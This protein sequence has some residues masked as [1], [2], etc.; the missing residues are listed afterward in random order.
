MLLVFSGLWFSGMTPARAGCPVQMTD[1]VRLI[2]VH[3]PLASA[4]AAVAGMGI[5]PSEAKAL[6]GDARSIRLTGSRANALNALGDRY[7][8]DW[9]CLQDGLHVQPSGETAYCMFVEHPGGLSWQQFAAALRGLGAFGASFRIQAMHKTRIA[10]IS[11]PPTLV[12]LG[13]RLYHSLP[14][15]GGLRIANGTAITSI[16]PGRADEQCS[17]LT[18]GQAEQ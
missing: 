15:S 4:T 13:R 16:P 8:F 17:G 18:E 5:K 9:W 14:Q 11:G 1:Q 6:S 10:M 2:V 3:Q 7:G 12:A